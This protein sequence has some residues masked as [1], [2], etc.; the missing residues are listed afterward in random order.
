MQKMQLWQ[1]TTNLQYTVDRVNGIG[2][3]EKKWTARQSEGKG[4]DFF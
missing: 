1:E 4:Q 3:K 2:K